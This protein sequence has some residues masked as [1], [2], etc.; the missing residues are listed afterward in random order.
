MRSADTTIDVDDIIE[1][2]D[3]AAAT[4][5]RKALAARLNKRF[6]DLIK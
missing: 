1:K 5:P 3:L 4:F 2:M 6:A